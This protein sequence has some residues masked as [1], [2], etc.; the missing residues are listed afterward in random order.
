MK[1][2]ILFFLIL[3]SVAGYSQFKKFNTNLIKY[4]SKNAQQPGQLPILI[5]GEMNSIVSAQNQIGFK[6]NYSYGSIARITANP[7]QI[8]ALAEK[9]FVTRIELIENK[10]IK[11]LNDTMRVRNNINPVQTGMAPLSQAYKGNGVV[12]GMI[13]SGHDFTHPDFKDS[14]TGKSRILKI[15]DQTFPVSSNTPISFGYGQEWDSSAFNSNN[16]PHTDVA[17]YG[18]G[19]HTAGIAGSNGGKSGQCI[20]VAPKSEFL[21]VA[22]DFYAI[23]PT[24]SDA[25]HYIFSEATALG[26]PC[27][28]NASVGDYY[29]SHDGKDLQSQMIDA[30]LQT[31][32]RLLVGAAGNSGNYKYHVGYNL[33]NDTNFTYI[34]NNTNTINFQLYA[35]VPQFI[36]ANYRIGAND[37]NFNHRG[38]TGFFNFNYALGTLKYDT[39]FNGL[40]RLAIVQTS[41]DTSMGVYTLDVTIYADSLNYKW[42]LDATGSG[43]FD[44]WNFD[45]FGT[46]LPSVSAHPEMQYYKYPDSLMTIVSGFQCLDNVVTVGNY[47]NMTSW[48][49]VNNNLQ[50][51][52]YTTGQISSMSSQGPTRDGRIKPDITASGDQILSSGVLSLMPSIIQNNPS[53]VSTDS[54]HV[55]GG[56]TSSS[57]PVVAGIGALFL[58]MQPQSIPSLFLQS[59]T[60]C[61]KQDIFTGNNLPN[62]VWGYGKVDGFAVMTC[63]ALSI[64]NI[65]KNPKIK[66]YPNPAQSEINFLPDEKYCGG[67][68]ILFDLMGKEIFF[69]KL[70][71]KES[72]IKILTDKLPS[73]LIYYKIE[74]EDKYSESGKLIITH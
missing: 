14:L 31:P 71:C 49:D 74:N 17:Y 68:L 39:I 5:K 69:Q 32:G 51:I 73:G 33:S 56:G 66:V 64:E 54:L 4:I 9:T 58:E 34:T 22:L 46:G 23:G 10:K 18:H 16:C 72:E 15:W 48:L 60:S 28:I 44:S 57:A 52:P 30:M 43:K 53:N 65:N 1:K 29:G 62:T 70:S 11:L 20:G 3:F 26:K 36:N 42:S 24:I 12:I 55:M 37:Q 38:Q 7:Q 6:L 13:D 8:L 27:V 2:Y 40:N 67:K 59:V 35:D 47:I 50:S 25:V 19:T 41:A 45:Y 63:T 21:S 61:A